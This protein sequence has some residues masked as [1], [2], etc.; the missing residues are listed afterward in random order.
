M[1]LGELGES[2]CFLEFVTELVSNVLVFLVEEVE[3]FSSPRVGGGGV[4]VVSD[5]ATYDG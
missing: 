2:D 4:V 3:A 1:S 5:G